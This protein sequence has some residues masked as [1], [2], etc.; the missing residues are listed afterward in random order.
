ML[1]LIIAVRV[2]AAET[3]AAVRA[4]L[5]SRLRTSLNLA[6]GSALG[7]PEPAAWKWSSSQSSGRLA[8]RPAC[9]QSVVLCA[10][11]RG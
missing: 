8:R 4:A 1:G 2:L 3:A 5:A 10:M 7:P 6:L 11:R 9:V